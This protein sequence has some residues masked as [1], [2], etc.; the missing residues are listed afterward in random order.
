MQFFVVAGDEVLTWKCPCLGL[1]IYGEHVGAGGF[2]GFRQKQDAHENLPRFGPREG[3]DLHHACLILYC[4]YSWSY[5]NGGAD[6]I[7]WRKKKIACAS[8]CTWDLLKRL[9]PSF[10]A[11]PP[12]PYMGGRGLGI[13]SKSVTGVCES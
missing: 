2:D 3:K 6:E 9:S 5:Y 10:L 7:W 4:L 1:S 13:R 8:L 11:A 12:R